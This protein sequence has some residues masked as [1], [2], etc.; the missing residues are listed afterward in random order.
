MMPLLGTL[1]LSANSTRGARLRPVLD[2]AANAVRFEVRAGDGPVEGTVARRGARCLLCGTAVPLDH[3][4]REGQ[5][6][7]L[8]VQMTTMVV[9]GRIGRLYLAADTELE[10]VAAKTTTSAV[11]DSSLPKQGLGFRVQ[12][13]GLKQHKDLFSPRQIA[14]LTT[15]SD[16]IAEARTA[17][18]GDG[19]SDDHASAIAVYLACS[20]DRS[21]DYWSTLTTWTPDGEFIGHTFTKQTVSM[22]WDYAECNPFAE[23]SGNWMGAV[24]WVARV[25]ENVPAAGYG[26]ST[27]LDATALD[28]N[29]RGVLI[30]TDPPY[31]DNIGYADL[32]DFFYVWLRR[33]LRTLF[34]EL[35]GT[36]LAPKAG[37]DC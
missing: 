5:A 10:M 7:R 35:F 17:A 28:A 11:P 24:D 30:S 26:R 31:Y 14:A 34:P 25:V 3:I 8:D 9:N 18:I 19:A 27:Q 1:A 23:A 20:V 21:A 12:N 36:L 2:H 13:Y 4:R 22:V 29:Q 32:S 37:N 33:S 6:H 15:F 16:L